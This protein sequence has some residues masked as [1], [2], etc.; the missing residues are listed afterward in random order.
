MSSDVCTYEGPCTRYYQ[1]RTLYGNIRTVYVC[2]DVMKNIQKNCCCSLDYAAVTC[3][4]V[5]ST[6]YVRALQEQQPFVTTSTRAHF[7]KKSRNPQPQR[8]ANSEH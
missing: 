7:D 6:K 5:A 3:R 1:V 8:T 2:H 4:P